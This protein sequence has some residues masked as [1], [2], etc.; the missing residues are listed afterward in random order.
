MYYVVYYKDTLKVSRISVREPN[1][2]LE[3]QGLARCEIR[4]RGL[5]FTVANIQTHTEPYT[6]TIQKEVVKV[7]EQG[8]EYE[9]FETIEITKIREYQTCEIVAK[10]YT[11]N[12]I[13]NKKAKEYEALVERF[14]RQKYSLSNELAI[15]RQASTKPEEYAVYN[16]YAEECKAKAKEII[17]KG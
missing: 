17:Y 3:N 16:A 1:D 11:Q 12:E 14:L 6:E 15:L 2:L 5:D 10:V 7:D 9:D 13:N 8:N 4:P